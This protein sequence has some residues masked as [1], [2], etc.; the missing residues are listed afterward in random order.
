VR[1]EGTSAANS[2]RWLLLQVRQ[3]QRVALEGLLGWCETQM[4]NGTR[5]IKDFHKAL[6]EGLDGE[7]WS[8]SGTATCA[9]TLTSFQKPFGS[10]DKYH[11]ACARGSDRC[12]FRLTDELFEALDEEASKAVEAAARLLIAT[13]ATT[14][15]LKGG[16]EELRP[17][18]AHG[19][20]DRISLSYQYEH[21]L[22]FEDRPSL[23]SCA[24]FWSA[25]SSAST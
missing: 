5:S 13:L 8:K 6:I 15:W 4:Q 11:E 22:R 2:R 18:L 16:E 10:E 3:A 20:V 1:L 17:A 24:T 21:F 23:N 25:G 12:F 7:S 14:A 19:G 9:A